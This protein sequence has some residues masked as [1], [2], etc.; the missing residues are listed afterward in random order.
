MAE[1]TKPETPVTPPA[2]AVPAAPQLTAADVKAATDKTMADE[3][4]RTSG[5]LSVCQKAGKPD[6]ASEF[7][8]NG[9]ALADVQSRMFDVLCASRP[10][11]GDAGGNDAPAEK[12]P[13]AAAKAEYAADRVMLQHA[14]VSETDYV[15]SRR[16]S[17]GREPLLIR[18]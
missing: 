6:M 16:I 12:D 9:T 10:P 17:E 4:A 2:P 5:I 18:K 3:R 7:I 15:T 13:D 1:Q 14:G 11:V 8:A